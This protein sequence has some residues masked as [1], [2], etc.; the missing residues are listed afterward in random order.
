MRKIILLL[1]IIVFSITAEAQPTQ[2]QLIWQNRTR[3]FI[4]F[5]PQDY[6]P[7]VQMPLV[8]NMHPFLT[9][10]PFQ[11]RYTKFNGI[12]DRE[13]V[14]VVY[15]SA[16][17]GTWN[18]GTFF[19]VEQPTDDLGFLNAL[20]DYMAVLYNIDT[21]RVYATGY[22]NGGYMSY[23]LACEASSRFAAI[24]PVA[25]TMNPDLMDVCNPDRPMPVM[26]FNGTT[27][28]LVPYEGS[29]VGAPIDD[30]FEL[31]RM[32]ND[33]DN[34][35]SIIDVPNINTFDNTTTQMFSYNNCGDRSEAILFKID[36]GGHTWPGRNF[37]L[38]GNTSQDIQANEEIWEFFSRH[39]IPDDIACDRPSDLT[40]DFSEGTASLSWEPVPG[41]DFY[42]LLHIVPDG[43]L[44]LI[45][46]IADPFYELEVGS[47]GELAWMVRAQCESG[48]ASWS[49]INR[50]DIAGRLSSGRLALHTYP[51]P[52]SE[53]IHLEFLAD[54]LPPS[55][56]I[57][58][59]YGHT[60]RTLA[61]QS[62]RMTLDIAGLTSGVFHII[63]S[64]NTYAPNTFRKLQ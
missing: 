1:S 30:I 19:G 60:I 41:I 23:T 42:S 11:M 21:R 46:D 43:E 16:I 39:Q 14:I 25:S 38:L 15:P 10:A 36:N 64:D 3:K 34:E 18:S 37:P 51:N 20:I 27:D 59:A 56:S 54:H 5:L 4:A 26:A 6:D 28:L 61:V 63:S 33:C 45:Q 47:D 17:R 55:I 12:A 9:N 44:E 62:P 31:W 53:Q 13:G 58:N 35:P 8:I 32:I 2:E 52:A 24:A 49:A 48:H 50:E 29:D 57:V 7:E 22:S 40:V